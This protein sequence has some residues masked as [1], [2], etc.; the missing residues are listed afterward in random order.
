MLPLYSMSLLFL[1]FLGPGASLPVLGYKTAPADA[2]GLPFDPS[3]LAPWAADQ[4]SRL[5]PTLAPQP[6]D[7]PAASDYRS[8]IQTVASEP[9]TTELQRENE[10]LRQRLNQLEQLM[11]K[12]IVSQPPVSGPQSPEAATGTK[13]V[14]G[15]TVE[16]H[17][18]NRNGQLAND[19]TDTLLTQNCA[20]TGDFARKHHTEMHL[21][22][23]MGTFRARENGRYVFSSDLECRRGHKCRFDLYVDNQP[24][25]QFSDDSDGTRLNNGLPL[26]AGDHTVEFRTW[27]TSNNFMKYDPGKQYRWHVMVKG[28]SDFTAR[29]FEPDELFSVIPSKVNMG[30]R[31]CT[32]L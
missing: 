31:A 29:D 9:S 6:L 27:L 19:A 32:Q 25:I 14:P 20:F 18:W 5:K 2:V 22:R 13:S 28:P 26:T 12:T 23:F 11:M 16:I 1:L 7:A 24:L 21:Y 15:W 3:R 10:E 8:L 17:P 30:A 4:F